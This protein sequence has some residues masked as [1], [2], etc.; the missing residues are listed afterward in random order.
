MP[1]RVRM[2][3]YHIAQ[4]FPPIAVPTY[5]VAQGQKQP[6]PPAGRHAWGGDLQNYSIPFFTRQREQKRS[7]S[8]NSGERYPISPLPV[9]TGRPCR[10]WPTARE[11]SLSSRTFPGNGHTYS[12]LALTSFA[13]S[14]D[15]PLQRQ[16]R[17]RSLEPD[18]ERSWKSPDCL[19][20]CVS[21]KSRKC[22]QGPSIRLMRK[23][24]DQGESMH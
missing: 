16:G 12:S 7:F 23:A 14:G 19:I 21:S 6:F 4:F 2:H 18:L 1:R 9:T 17:A 22:G 3:A 10:I 13:P 24:Q 20:V 5:F 15:K 11:R 8:E